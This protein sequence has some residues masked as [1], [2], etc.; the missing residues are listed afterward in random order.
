MFCVIPFL[1]RMFF[2]STACVACLLSLFASFRLSYCGRKAEQKFFLYIFI[3]NCGIQYI[4][5]QR[6]HTSIGAFITSSQGGNMLHSTSQLLKTNRWT[7]ATHIQ[8]SKTLENQ[9]QLLKHIYPHTLSSSFM[10]FR[11]SV[12]CHV[13]DK[14]RVT[15]FFLYASLAYIGIR[16]NTQPCACQ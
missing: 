12:S 13:F 3:V 1:G 11:R 10:S 15:F 14:N 4:G 5:I 2:Y 16:P 9:V 6:K 7:D 8:M